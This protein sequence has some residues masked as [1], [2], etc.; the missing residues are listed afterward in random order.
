MTPDYGHMFKNL[1][2]H[3]SL[4]ANVEYTLNPG[5]S[6]GLGYMYSR[7]SLEDVGAAFTSSLHHVYPFLGINFLNYALYNRNRKWDFW[8]TVGVGAVHTNSEILYVYDPDNPYYAPSGELI[9]E[10]IWNHPDWEIGYGQTKRWGVVVPVGFELSY[11][12]TKQV[13]IGL[14]YTHFLYTHDYLEGG[15]KLKDHRDDKYG[16]KNYAYQGSSNDHLSNFLLT[17]R[18][19]IAGEG[20]THMRKVGWKAFHERDR[21]PETPARVDT[22]VMQVPLIVAEEALICPCPE[23][24]YAIYFDFDKYNFTPE[25]YLVISQVAEKMIA[26]ES[27]GLEI[28]GYTDIDGTEKYN[29]V[30]SLRRAEATKDELVNKWG[31]SA[32]RISASGEGKM[33]VPDRNYHHVSRRCELIFIK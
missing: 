23:P 3:W 14:K 31:I 5:F 16:R 29:E 26:D 19:D 11:N 10:E 13:A 25:A 17:V 4:G 6:M 20:K 7:T 1:G 27:L 32:D 28:Y 21:Q 12:I 22:V 8:I 18:W 2:D 9:T 15:V 33:R 24:S 30:L